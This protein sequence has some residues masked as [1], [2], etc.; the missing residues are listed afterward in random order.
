MWADK[1][2]HLLWWPQAMGRSVGP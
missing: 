1:P 2:R